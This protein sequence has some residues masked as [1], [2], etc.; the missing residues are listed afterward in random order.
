MNNVLKIFIGVVIFLGIVSGGYLLFVKNKK[1]EPVAPKTIQASAQVKPMTPL[2]AQQNSSALP[3]LKKKP[4]VSTGGAKSNIENSKP[5]AGLQWTEC[6]AK[7]FSKTT[8]LLWKV[9]ITEGIPVGGTYAKG[10]LEGDVAFPVQVTIKTDSLIVDKIK[11]MLVVGKTA[12]LRGTCIDV[13]TDGSV[14]LQAF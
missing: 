7:T 6:K 3:T 8:Q 5:S 2:P 14:V 13:A 10:N 11:T 1:V 12:F 4:S 9:Q